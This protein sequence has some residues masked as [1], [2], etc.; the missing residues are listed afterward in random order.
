MEGSGAGS[1]LVTDGSGCGSSGR[2]KNI[3]ILALMGGWISGLLV[4]F[5]QFPCSRIQIRIRFPST[6][7]IWIQESQINAD[8]D[9]Q[10]WY[11]QISLAC[12]EHPLILLAQ[13]AW[14]HWRVCAEQLGVPGRAVW[15]A[16]PLRALLI[17]GLSPPLC[18]ASLQPRHDPHCLLLLSLQLT[19]PA[20]HLITWTVYLVIL[21]TFIVPTW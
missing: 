20:V 6:V 3:R 7:R 21:L 11:T 1:V 9:P 5:G 14:A 10:H 4:Y 8:P 16:H 13:G 18:G 17:Q 15:P 2:P 12:L 19:Q